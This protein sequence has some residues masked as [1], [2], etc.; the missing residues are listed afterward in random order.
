MSKKVLVLGMVVVL[1][2]GGVATYF[3]VDYSQAQNSLARSQLEVR[4]LGENITRH[5]EDVGRLKEMYKLANIQVDLLEKYHSR[6]IDAE[7]ISSLKTAIERYR[8]DI[9]QLA[10]AAGK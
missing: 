9:D 6:W 1:A 7:E 5:P 8:R 3:W 10:G 4:S 2:I